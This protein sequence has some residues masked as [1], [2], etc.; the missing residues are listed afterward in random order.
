MGAALLA[1]A[2]AAGPADLR[3]EF[4]SPHFS[5]SLFC[6]SC[7]DHLT[8]KD[9]RGVGINRD[10]GGSMMAHS[11]IDPLWQAKVQSE[12]KRNP[13]IK[14]LIVKKCTTCHAP[15]ANHESAAAGKKIA[16]FGDGI[17][18]PKN[19]YHEM[20]MEG[21]SCTLCHQIENSPFL[22]S[23]KSFSGHFTIAAF[24]TPEER[25]AYGP[26]KDIIGTEIMKLTV[27]FT[28]GYGPHMEQ[29]KLCGVCHSLLTPYVDSR[30]KVVSTEETEFPEQMGFGEWDASAFSE[31]GTTPKPCQECHMPPTSGVKIS[32]VPPNVKVR[33]K[34]FQHTFFSGNALLQDILQTNAETLGVTSDQLKEQAE[35]REGY[36]RSAA[37]LKVVKSSL[38]DGTL[39]V[40]L[41]VVNRTGHKL[42]SGIPIRRVYIHFT[43]TDEKGS[44]VFESGRT[45]RDRSIPGVDADGDEYAFEPHHDVITKPDQVQVY[46]SI[47]GDTESGVTYTLLRAKSYLKDNRLL[48]AGFRKTDVP[49]EIRPT[50]EPLRDENFEAGG[51]EIT[52]RIAGLKGKKF[53]VR[54]DLDDQSTSYQFIRDLFRDADQPE[55][56]RFKEMYE[57]SP[58][59]HATIASVEA[60]VTR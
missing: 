47:M 33:D 25:I 50:A 42:P 5:S 58:V 9:K 52:Y 54:A 28:P 10:E 4:T 8:D 59:T 3:A 35:K 45:N 17:T 30:G 57:K 41:K 37:E 23:R 51:D 46:E 7:H 6:A 56:R 40:R 36:L 2:F 39:E 53:H 55:V 1:A 21:V 29:A 27:Q 26:F 38:Q 16:M 18:N 15:M 13:Q 12:I 43:V 48:P 20:A 22:G 32:S 11:F 31:R 44:T 60:D 34:F 24:S 19:E 14:D 49:P